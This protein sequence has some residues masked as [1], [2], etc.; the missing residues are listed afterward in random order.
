MRYAD[1]SREEIQPFIDSYVEEYEQG[2]G[3]KPDMKAIAQR[4][5][6]LAEERDRKS[7]FQRFEG[8]TGNSLRLAAKLALEAAQYGA[9]E[10]NAK[11]VPSSTEKLGSDNLDLGKGKKRAAKKGV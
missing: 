6:E 7:F 10:N 8:Y 11:D 2:F 1:K 9:G 4:F 3:K 5:L